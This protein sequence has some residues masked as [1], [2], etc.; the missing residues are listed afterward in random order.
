L[1]AGFDPGADLA[2]LV[3]PRASDVIERRIPRDSTTGGRLCAHR[4]NSLL[5]YMEGKAAYDCVELDVVL[6]TSQRGDGPAFVY[7]PPVAN[8][9]LPLYDLLARTG[10]PRAG[11]WL[12]VK[13]LT[14]R[15]LPAMLSR[16]S[17][18]IPADTRRLV[19]VESNNL[20]LAHSPVAR[21]IADSGFVLSY[22]VSTELGCRCARNFDGECLREASRLVQR[23]NGGV[24]GG[25][26]FD[27]RGRRLARTIHDEITPRLVLNTW[28]VGDPCHSGPQGMR[29]S[30]QA[31][32]SLLQDVQKYLVT[33]PS[34][35]AY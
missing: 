25:L 5:K 34:A 33:L 24:F 4:G 29:V 7:H 27:A 26:S 20:S 23:L 31:R 3:A 8:P 14:E 6:D 11:L 12:D 35:F 1:E 2:A 17:A 19:L 15:N 13:N 10:I 22:Y 32:D 28:E 21:A 18:L 16:L 9:R 30:D